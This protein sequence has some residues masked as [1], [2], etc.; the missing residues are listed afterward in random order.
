MQVRYQAA[1][2]PDW[3][4]TRDV[5]KDLVPEEDSTITIYGDQKAFHWESVYKDVYFPLAYHFALYC[6]R[7][8]CTKL[9]CSVRIKEDQSDSIWKKRS[10]RAAPTLA[11]DRAL[12]NRNAFSTL[13][14]PRYLDFAVIINEIVALFNHCDELDHTHHVINHHYIAVSFFHDGLAVLYRI[15]GTR[16][17]LRSLPLCKA[18]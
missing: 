12:P 10:K 5:C 4:R 6:V 15:R 16:A 7:V 2:R 3:A 1:L 11:K 18:K 8:H 14:V 13:R 17:I 9:F